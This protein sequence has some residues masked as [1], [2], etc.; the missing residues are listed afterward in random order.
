MKTIASNCTQAY[1]P[2]ATHS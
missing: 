1:K 2:L